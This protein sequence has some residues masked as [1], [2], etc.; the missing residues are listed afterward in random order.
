MPLFHV[1]ICGNSGPQWLGRQG[2]G[3]TGEL[4]AASERRL[5]KSTRAAELWSAGPLSLRRNRKRNELDFPPATR[6][7]RESC[8]RS[9]TRPSRIGIDAPRIDSKAIGR[10][11]PRRNKRYRAAERKAREHPSRT[12]P[13]T[14][15]ARRRRG[16]STAI[17]SRHTFPNRYGNR[18][19]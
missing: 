6:P 7:E 10:I 3:R 9:R 13:R 2:G 14:R 1:N 17:D 16:R 5:G 8:D 15:Q 12:C 19:E 4:A 11:R 18:D